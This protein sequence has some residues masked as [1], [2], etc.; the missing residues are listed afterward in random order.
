[1]SKR[2]LSILLIS[3]ATFCKAR[4]T[5]RQER[6][7]AQESRLVREEAAALAADCG[8]EGF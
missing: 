5:I 2:R 4:R 6:N 8:Y 3:G 1:M 7:P